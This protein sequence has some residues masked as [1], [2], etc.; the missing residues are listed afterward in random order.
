MVVDVILAESG[1][2]PVVLY[3]MCRFLNQPYRGGV[4]IYYEEGCPLAD[5][6]VGTLVEQRMHRWDSFEEFFARLDS[7]DDG[8][9][10]LLLFR[11]P[12]L[13]KALDEL[14]RLATSPD[15][16]F[17]AWLPTDVYTKQ[18]HWRT[19]PRFLPSVVCPD[20]GGFAVSAPGTTY[21]LAAD[22]VQQATC[23]QM[24]DLEDKMTFRR[25]F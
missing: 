14:H 3:T 8:S 5:A 13:I 16:Y 1:Q 24:L 4:A 23:R 21:F 11:I 22:D 20:D 12:L 7:A 2:E 25:V 17:L 19:D 15:R 6:F 18:S 10:V 9:Q